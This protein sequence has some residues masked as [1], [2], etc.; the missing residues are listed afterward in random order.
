MVQDANQPARDPVVVCQHLVKTFRDFW[1][2]PRVRAVDDVSFT[3][4]RGE[5]FGLLGP[6]GSGKSTTIKMILGLLHQTSGRVAVLG[7]LPSDVSIKKRI[8]YLPEE[9]YL[10]QFLD[11]RE[12]LDY[13][14]K[15]FELDR[16]TRLRRI[17]ELL[18]MVGLTAV[19][20]RQVREYS[21]GMQRRI[22]IAQALINDPEFL[23][24]DEPT[25][26]LDPIGSK[27]IK[28][29]IVSLGRRGK[30]VLLSS[31]MLSDV[32]D[33]VDRMV[34][35]YGGKIRREGT[36]EQLLSAEDRAII[37]TDPLDDATVSA[38]DRVIRERSGGAKHINRVA[39][40]RQRLEDLFVQIVESARA[41]RVE[42]HGAQHG[43]RTAAF[44]RGEGSEEAR[45]DELISNLVSA[46]SKK[47][48]ELESTKGPGEAAAASV[49][50]APAHDE[51]VL[52]KL[53]KPEEESGAASRGPG[54]VS[55]VAPAP[56]PKPAADVDLNVIGSLL[57]D[58][59]ETYPGD[60]PP[61]R[62]P[63]PER[64]P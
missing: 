13:Y 46:G 32:E 48:P 41:E 7:K 4:E 29:L 59:P 34:I 39:K 28:D 61:A 26:G 22:G 58:D 3:I 51:D 33:C 25:T 2:R 15:L 43:G 36:C 60:E 54:E 56:A 30:T 62:K 35:L 6:N 10:Y 23:I 24:L 21:K 55:R 19:Q 64:K 11:A 5:I 1:H 37:E 50:A 44:L 38:I 12:T 8:G 49:L 45:G 27:Q 47:E 17:E 63:G 57:D 9:S 31:H 42:T 16:R 52:R 40:G 53:L 20:H 18:D 14:G